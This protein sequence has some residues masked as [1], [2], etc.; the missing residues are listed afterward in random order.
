MK[1]VIEKYIANNNK[2]YQRYNSWNHCYNAFGNH[3]TSQDTLALHLGFYLASWGMYRGSSKL[4]QN[5]YKVHIKA[6]NI[7]NN[8]KH[9]RCNQNYEVTLSNLTEILILIKKL[10][11]YYGKKHRVTPTNTL[12]S[13]IILG[14]LGCLPAYD[15]FFI[16]GVKQ[17]RLKST[18]LKEKSLRE[19]FKFI[20]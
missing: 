14:S 2:E 4:L 11:N 1:D 5:D 20:E 3:S 19:L 15:R 8:F 17:L 9:L 10:S 16:S 7:L 18:T 6:V 13:K 12:I